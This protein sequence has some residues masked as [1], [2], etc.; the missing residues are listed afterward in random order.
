MVTGKR[1]LTTI[2]L[3]VEAMQWEGVQQV[4]DAMEKASYT[5]MEQS[6]RVGHNMRGN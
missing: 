3:R 6:S 5:L 4:K 2:W 1:K